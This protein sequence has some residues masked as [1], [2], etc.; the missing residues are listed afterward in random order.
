MLF[1]QAGTHGEPGACPGC[2]AMSQRAHSRYERRLSDAAVAG[3][4]V[5]IRLRVRR[6]FCDNSDCVGRTSVEQVPSVAVR[7]ARRTTISAHDNTAAAA[8]HGR[9]GAGWSCRCPADRPRRGAVT[10]TSERIRPDRA[11]FSKKRKS[12]IYQQ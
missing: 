2:G 5:L 8:V 11:F 10:A 9:A 7:H 12:A 1:I 6:L 3:R 4:E